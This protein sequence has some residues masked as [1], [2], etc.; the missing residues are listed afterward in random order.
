M[1]SRIAIP[2]EVGVGVLLFTG[3]VAVGISLVLFMDKATRDQSVGSL[4]D[5]LDDL[6]G[7]RCADCGGYRNP[8][9]RCECKQGERNGKETEP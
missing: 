6:M 7:M 8:K 3:G 9:N 2:Q 4:H 5:R 1:N